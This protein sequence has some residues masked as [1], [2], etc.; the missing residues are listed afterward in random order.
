MNIFRTRLDITIATSL[1]K[2]ASYLQHLLMKVAV[3]VS[4]KL[5]LFTARVLL[6][7]SPARNQQVGQL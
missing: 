4:L 7:A 1:K 6:S 5:C 3:A 2:S